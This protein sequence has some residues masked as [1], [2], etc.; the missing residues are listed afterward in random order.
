M[1]C[2]RGES[3]GSTAAAIPPCARS[4]EAGRH[5]RDARAQARGLERCGGTREAVADDQDVSGNLTAEIG[6]DHNS[7]IR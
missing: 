1:A 5:E 2:S 4:D 6:I 7:T 3:S